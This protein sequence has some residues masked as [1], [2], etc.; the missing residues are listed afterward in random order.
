MSAHGA[1]RRSALSQL[2]VATVAAEPHDLLTLAEDL[3]LLQVVQKLQIALFV[4]LFDLGYALELGGQGQEALLLGGAG[5]LSIHLGPLFVFAGSG[6]RQVL[7]GGA[8]TAEGLEPQLGMLL[9]IE[10]RLL[11]N[12]CDLLVALLLGLAGKIVVLVAGL[13]L[14]RKR[15]PQIGLRLAPLQF[16]VIESPFKCS[17][18]FP[19]AGQIPLKIRLWL[20]T[21]QPS[22]AA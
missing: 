11:E 10:R 12:G 9:L 19:H 18:S 13:G 7:L 5:H 8:D 15:D 14:P 4:S 22:R 3:A 1:H 21:C 16:H 2:H 20:S 6:S 17:D